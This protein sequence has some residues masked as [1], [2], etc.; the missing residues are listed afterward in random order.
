MS[1]DTTV[2][3]EQMLVMVDCRSSE[4]RQL[5]WEASLDFVMGHLHRQWIDAFLLAP[6]HVATVLLHLYNSQFQRWET[7]SSAKPS[8]PLST[9]E[10][11]ETPVLVVD[12]MEQAAFL[13]R[14][15]EEA[16][17][18]NDRTCIVIIPGYDA[19]HV[20][21]GRKKNIQDAK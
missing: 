11:H 1:S 10:K 3:S 21:T 7:G 15:K 20:L 8:K 13:Q 9:Q 6:E 4:T 5:Y 17:S 12:A 2:A 16:I 19:G 18:T 14:G